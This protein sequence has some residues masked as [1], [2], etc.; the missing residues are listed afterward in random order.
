M[1]EE[2]LAYH[3]MMVT[4]FLI[5]LFMD[6]ALPYFFRRER[7]REIKMTRISFFVYTAMLTMVAFSGAVL[8][9]VMKSG[10]NAGS[11]L[12]V[13]LF[14]FLAA[15][16]IARSRKLTEV[17]RRGESA[18]AYSWPYVVAEITATGLMVLYMVIRAQYAVSL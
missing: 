15:A 3:S 18:F 16:E 12:M 1:A 10:W 8:F 7:A 17:W 9:M 14:I 11:V 2:I 5:V 6:L 13:L 4:L